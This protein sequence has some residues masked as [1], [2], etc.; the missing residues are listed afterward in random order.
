MKRMLI[1][2]TQPEEVRI[3]LVD[4]QKLYDFDIE[5]RSREQKKGN[6]YKARIT[7]VEPS[8][9]AAFVDFGT[10]RHGFLSLKEIA[11]Q[12]LNRR[13]E[14]GRPQIQDAVTEGQDLIVQVAKEERGTKGAA[15][16][17]FVSL[18]GR[19]LVLM[20]NNPRA[21]GVSRRIEGED[22]DQ[23]R[24][25]L[26]QLDIPQG[27]GLIVRTVGVG[28]GTEELGWDME[29]LLQLW[30]QIR[31]AGEN[32][33]A[34][35]LLYAESNVI[36]RAIRDNLRKDIGELLIDSPEAYEQA[37]SFV[38]GVMPHY[39]NRTKYYDE[40]VP[41][42]SRYQIE[43]QIESAFKHTVKLPS[44]GSIVIDPTEAL[45]SIDINSARATRGTDIE[46]TALNTNLEAAEE[47]AR[48][49]RLRD[50]GGL[51]VI[52]F[53]DMS[54]VKNQRTVENKMREALE[55]DRARVQLGRI[56]RF[57]LLE[58]SRQRLRP[59]LSELTTEA[60]PRCAGQG[61]I[62]DVKSLAL[63]ILRVM[64]EESLKERSSLVRALV[65]LNI[66]TYLLNEKRQ[67]VAEIER[68]TETH[69]VIVP[70]VNMETPQYEVQRIRDD[71]AV[72]E[73]DVPS[74]ELTEIGNQPLDT[75]LRETAAEPVREQ[76]AVRTQQPTAPEPVPAAGRAQAENGK[77]GLL[78]RVV[79]SLFSDG[80][81]EATG[82]SEPKAMVRDADT[83][84]HRSR[85]HSNRRRGTGSDRPSEQTR[86]ANKDK[87]K[88]EHSKGA[89]RKG[90][91]N[92]KQEKT[93]KKGAG[94]KA[95][96]QPAAKTRESGGPPKQKSDGKARHRER[97]DEQKTRTPEAEPSR[98]PPK[99]RKPS[100]DTLAQ[101][102]RRPR[103]DRSEIAAQ[104]GREKQAQATGK[105][106]DT[107]ESRPDVSRKGDAQG[108]AGTSPVAT[109]EIPAS[110]PVK[111]GAS[112]PTR[113]GAANQQQD[114]DNDTGR[115]RASPPSGTTAKS[116]AARDSGAAPAGNDTAGIDNA[117]A[118][119]PS[120]APDNSASVSK[121]DGQPTSKSRH[122]RALNDP[123]EIRRRQREE[124]TGGV[125][126]RD[127]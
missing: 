84:R 73:I 124:T 43:S 18:A 82:G 127:T 114:S 106:T 61:R 117:A 92:A 76:A 24:E 94:T 68:R 15:L 54:S 27:M 63:A 2:A 7:R 98:E 69:I 8:L 28:R 126:S 20:P 22:R 45:V 122:R 44:G 74:Y 112:N 25:V 90:G 58:M 111:S 109:I 48:Q 60:C 100:D 3:A 121:A 80:G 110:P 16:T 55:Q 71:R 29:Y 30:E 35:Q 11:T 79:A 34:P 41:L 81:V 66:A 83:G 65:P 5:N 26:S 56:S 32:K 9:E 123:R 91:K 95:N 77:P 67:D 6:I 78:R 23:L 70:N 10:A 118:T 97:G 113:D 52:D 88:G 12:Y 99:N 125:E 89:E 59:S 46:E 87:K 96:D 31:T 120:S 37:R 49:L 47:I 105:S 13:S 62:R 86:N 21:G 1:N 38:D 85:G 14:D 19:Y 103:R 51:I 50:M 115:R 72:D 17:T 119:G 93:R 39:S 107:A 33:K 64:E 53:I 40:A 102:K 108:R 75:P 101:S 57:G 116:N 104:T 4:G 42:F 36:V